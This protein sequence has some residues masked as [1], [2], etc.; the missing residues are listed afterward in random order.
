MRMSNY[1][2]PGSLD[3]AIDEAVRVMTQVE[4][5]P[6]LRN[7]VVQSIR[8]PRPR[9]RAL[10]FGFAALALAMIVLASVLIL[11]RPDLAAPVPA[12]QV[13]DTTPAAPVTLIAGPQAVETP[14]T[15]SAPAPSA[16]APRRRT[17]PTPESIFGPRRDRIAATSVPNAPAASR[18]EGPWL[19]FAGSAA[20]RVALSPISLAPIQVVPLAIQPLLAGSRPVRK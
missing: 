7:R 14:V 6:G 15:P 3:G 11:R 18:L 13:A 10:Q 5:R 2:K 19:E 9:R 1:D 17:E 4:P 20:G 8:A 16:V 12:T